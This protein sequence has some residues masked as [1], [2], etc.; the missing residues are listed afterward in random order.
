MIREA[1]QIHLFGRLTEHSIIIHAH[2]LKINN[3]SGISY[4]RVCTPRQ[5]LPT[6]KA[7]VYC[8]LYLAV[9]LNYKLVCYRIFIFTSTLQFN[10]EPHSLSSFPFNY[11]IVYITIMKVLQIY[12]AIFLPVLQNRSLY[13]SKRDTFFYGFDKQFVSRN[14]KKNN[15]STP[16]LG[17]LTKYQ[18]TDR[19][20][21]MQTNKIK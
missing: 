5:I 19:S 15:N 6:N 10:N 4:Q 2:H 11:F 16:K 12:T 17:L 8:V 1:I 7:T 14:K 9:L 20:D 13:C 21:L 3:M 18:T